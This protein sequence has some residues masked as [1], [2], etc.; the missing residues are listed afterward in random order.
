MQSW[1]VYILLKLTF[2]CYRKLVLHSELHLSHSCATLLKICKCHTCT[3]ETEWNCRLL[4]WLV[5][6]ILCK[7]ILLSAYVH[8]ITESP[9]L[10][11][12]EQL[13]YLHK[14]LYFK[15]TCTC[16]KLVSSNMHSFTGRHSGP[17]E[18][19]LFIIVRNTSH[20]QSQ[21][22]VAPTLL[23]ALDCNEHGMMNNKAEAS[24]LREGQQLK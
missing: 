18:N 15:G 4:G 22:L 5:M 11:M 16:T 7:Y 14:Y 19:K 6:L 10:L 8:L 20:P 21:Q 12:L 13:W 17:W 24:I 2:D 3:C 1:Y 9:Q 23:L